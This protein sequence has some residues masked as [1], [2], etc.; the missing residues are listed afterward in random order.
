MLI[1]VVKTKLVANIDDVTVANTL[2][3]KVVLPLSIDVTSVA[4][5]GKVN[6]GYKVSFMAKPIETNPTSIAMEKAMEEIQ[7]NTINVYLAVDD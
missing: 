7:I 2:E 3:D 1:H 6:V 4:Q 5:I